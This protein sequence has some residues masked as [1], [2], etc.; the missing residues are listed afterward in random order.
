MAIVIKTAA[1][2]GTARHRAN[3]VGLEPVEQMLS[4]SSVPTSLAPGQPISKPEVS[5]LF[6]FI[7]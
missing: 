5:Q 3:R 4:M 1:L 2:A 7:I 6:V